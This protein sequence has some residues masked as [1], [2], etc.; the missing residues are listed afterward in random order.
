[1]NIFGVKGH[2]HLTARSIG[3]SMDFKGASHSGLI[4][5]VRFLIRVI[6]VSSTK[7]YH[8]AFVQIRQPLILQESLLQD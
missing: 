8:L 2:L 6:A 3:D 5:N 4:T 1:M 7:G